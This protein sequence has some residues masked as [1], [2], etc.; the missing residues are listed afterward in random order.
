M[1]AL[2]SHP[3]VFCLSLGLFSCDRLATAL[4]NVTV[5]NN[6]SDITY[7]GRWDPVTTHPDS[8]MNDYRYTSNPGTWATFTFT[9]V[10]IYYIAP[11][12]APLPFGSSPFI[13]LDGSIPEKVTLLSSK[14]ERYAVRWAK[15]G[16][17]NSHHEVSVYSCPNVLSCQVNDY[18]V[19][20]DGFIFTVQDEVSSEPMS[21]P[22]SS[23]S[24]PPTSSPYARSSSSTSIESR[25]SPT[26]TAFTS[27]STLSP[28]VVQPSSSFLRSVTSTP[29]STSSPP[30]LK[31]TFTPS[32]SPITPAAPLSLSSSDS[33][34]TS[35]VLSRTQHAEPTP[36]GPIGSPLSDAVEGEARLSPSQK[37]GIAGGSLT[38]GAAVVTFVIVAAANSGHLVYVIAPLAAS[39]FG[40][41]LFNCRKIY[42]VCNDPNLPELQTSNSGS[43]VDGHGGNQQLVWKVFSVGGHTKD[44]EVTV[45]IT[46]G[47]SK[48]AGRPKIGF[49]T[50][51]D[52]DYDKRIRP[53]FWQLAP[54]RLLE[55]GKWE[56]VAEENDQSEEFVAENTTGRNQ[57]IAMGV[58]EC[59]EDQKGELFSPFL[60]I[61]SKNFEP[62]GK[63]KVKSDIYVHA[64]RTGGCRGS[65]EH[66][67]NGDCTEEDIKEGDYG[68]IVMKARK[69]DRLTPEGGYR[70]K[71]F[72]PVGITSFSSDINEH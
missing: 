39:L 40:L 18:G 25:P 70:V 41:V 4:R 29:L 28:S 62:H 55:D 35:L 36:T 45:P 67:N 26:D 21:S 8:Y 17:N 7:Y 49:G 20:V 47:R 66:A 15:T 51:Y 59:A 52:D 16:L 50:V 10:A 32:I 24:L 53:Q 60:V 56:H 65:Y 61:D 48:V 33:I 71:D 63:F 2:F 27:I 1:V 13:S 30:T 42:I 58:S 14:D 68:D 43:H 34:R 5:N 37:G 69:R 11:L 46:T 3:L 44:F 12:F 9:G 22:S 19:V 72:N 6:S 64:F 31:S 38:G 54:A 23:I 57:R